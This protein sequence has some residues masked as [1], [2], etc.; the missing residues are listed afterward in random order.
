MGRTRGLYDVNTASQVGAVRGA[1]IEMGALNDRS[2]VLDE[3]KAK[4]EIGRSVRNNQ[5][6]VVNKNRFELK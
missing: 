4:E 2:S 1:D 5:Y 3:I 6:R